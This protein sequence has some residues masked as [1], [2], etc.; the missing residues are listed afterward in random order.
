[1]ELRH[2][3]HFLALAELGSFRLASER[4]HLTPQAVSKSIAQLEDRI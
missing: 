3:R 2:L 4:V 1:M